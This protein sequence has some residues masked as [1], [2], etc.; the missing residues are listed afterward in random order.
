[1]HHGQECGTEIED[2]IA[3]AE[4]KYHVISNSTFAWWAAYLSGGKV[5][6]PKQWFGT[7]PYSTEDLLPKSWEVI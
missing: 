2:F 6:A 1:L 5:V 7:L 3:L 4:C